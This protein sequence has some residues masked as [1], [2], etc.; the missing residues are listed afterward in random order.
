MRLFQM[1]TNYL[2]KHRQTYNPT[3]ES[4]FSYHNYNITY[5]ES[6]NSSPRPRCEAAP[7]NSSVISCQLYTG[8]SL[9]SI[10]GSL[11]SA[12]MSVYWNTPNRYY[13][14]ND[15]YSKHF[16]EIVDTAPH[17][18]CECYTSMNQWI[19]QRRVK[20]GSSSSSSSSSSI[21]TG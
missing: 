1:L 17:W 14:R 10:T 2:T 21:G 20:T 9:R 12:I 5:A 4:R 7:L 6:C 8:R 19:R 11:S 16:N 18:H 15:K 3:I 13:R